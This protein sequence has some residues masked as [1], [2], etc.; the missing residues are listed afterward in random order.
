[1]SPERTQIREV[2]E[3]MIAH[4]SA[5]AEPIQQELPPQPTMDFIRS[6]IL[7]VPVQQNRVENNTMN[8]EKMIESQLEAEV[9]KIE[10]SK[11][12]VDT[13]T[14]D[15]PL[16]MRLLEY[17]R[18]DAKTDMDLHDIAER[19]IALNKENKVLSMDHYEKIVQK[20]DMSEPKDHYAGDTQYE[21]IDSLKKLAGIR[22]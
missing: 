3:S 7:D 5:R 21:N 16:L 14:V 11:D 2:A 9:K 20:M 15:V 10:K 18:E 22:Q 4:Q 1:M 19:L 8:I 17:A 13:V 12:P 6:L